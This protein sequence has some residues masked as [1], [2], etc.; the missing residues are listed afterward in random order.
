[1]ASPARNEPP[2][3]RRSKTMIIWKMLRADII[4]QTFEA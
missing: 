2:V 3:P 4:V 1:M